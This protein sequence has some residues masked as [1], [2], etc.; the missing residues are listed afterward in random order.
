MFLNHINYDLTLYLLDLWVAY[1]VEWVALRGPGA[2]FPIM[3]V[4]AVCQSSLVSASSMKECCPIGHAVL[5]G[6]LFIPRDR[7]GVPSAEEPVPA[8]ISLR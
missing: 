3:A 6:C 4:P 7:S 8:P 5:H 1:P 2:I